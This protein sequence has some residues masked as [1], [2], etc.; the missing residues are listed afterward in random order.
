VIGGRRYP[1]PPMAAPFTVLIMAAGQGTRMH[2]DTPK[3]LHRVAGKPLVEWVADAARAAGAERVVAIVRPG[4]G[5]EEGLPDGIEVAQQREGEGTGAAVLAARDAVLGSGAG[6]ESVPV[7]V[8][9]GDHPLVTAEQL[10]GLMGE[11]ARQDAK[12]TLLTTDQLNP[13]GYGRIV[14]DSD[15]TVD[16]IYE[17]K[18][19]DGLTPE[20]LSV[21]EINLGAYVFDPQTLFD[22]LDNVG[23]EQ[24]ERYLT[25]VFPLI[26][27]EDGTIAAYMTDDADAA[28]GINDRAGLMAAEEAA[29]RRIIEEHAHSG[30]TFLQPGTTRVEAGVTIGRDTT[31]GPGTVLEGATVI[32]E[33]CEIGPHTTLRGATIRDGATVVHSFVIEAEVGADAKVGPFAYLRPGTVIGDGAKAGTFVEIKN[34]DIGARAK[35]PHLSYI[36]DTDVG[37]DSNLGASTI[38]ANYDGRKKHRTKLGKSVKTGIHT[39]LVAPLDIGDRAY[40]GAGS[41]INEDVPDGALGIGRAKQK[42]IEGYADRVEEDS[43]K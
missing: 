36:G 25:G 18:Y 21:R 26:R 3:V 13:T 35:V 39:S 28:L 5:V 38:T 20:E 9:S 41:T 33:R 4:D 14:R 23:L 22:A 15:G 29:Q 31:I 8:L 37:E 27:A 24:G 34:S 10:Q 11:H 17:T 19:T 16:R 2:S 12:A 43:Q 40:T 1:H 42:N 32:G 30:V 6:A 7:V